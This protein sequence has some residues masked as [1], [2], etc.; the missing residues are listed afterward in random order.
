MVC[1]VR[2]LLLLLCM[3]AE[4]LLLL[5]L[6]LLCF[7]CCDSYTNVQVLLLTLV[8]LLYEQVPVGHSGTFT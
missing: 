4:C 6:V 7:L 3:L 1:R 5:R 2:I 8:L